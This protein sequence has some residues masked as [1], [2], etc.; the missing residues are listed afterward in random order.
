MCNNETLQ[1][2]LIV[3]KAYFFL[4]FLLC[5]K[6]HQ[7]AKYS[8]KSVTKRHFSVTFGKIHHLFSSSWSETF[9]NVTLPKAVTLV[10]VIERVQKRLLDLLFE[11]VAGKTFGSLK[12]HFYI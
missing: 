11:K 6:N 5:A 1:L 4:L 2:H 3:E 9:G 12:R 7:L 8:K 10:T